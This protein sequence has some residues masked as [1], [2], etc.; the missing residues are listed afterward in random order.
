MPNTTGFEIN[1]PSAEL[2]IEMA[3]AT[4]YLNFST[5]YQIHDLGK[6]GLFLK[7]GRLFMFRGR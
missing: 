5:L 3:L 2:A 1:G 6:F 7:N 4:G